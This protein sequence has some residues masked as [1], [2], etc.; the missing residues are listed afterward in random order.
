MPCNICAH[1]F[2]QGDEEKKTWTKKKIVDEWRQA[3]FT[4]FHQ[5]QNLQKK[6]KLYLQIYLSLSS[7]FFVLVFCAFSKYGTC[8]SQNSPINS[9][10]LSCPLLLALV[11]FSSVRPFF[12]R[13]PKLYN[14]KLRHRR[15]E[16]SARG[17]IFF[18]N[19]RS[20]PDRPFGYFGPWTIGTWI[21]KIPLFTLGKYL[22]SPRSLPWL[23]YKVCLFNIFKI[24]LPILMEFPVL[25]W[26]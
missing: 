11:R 13:R 4:L 22:R 10:N 16:M 1:F 8:L 19:R 7:F 21:V 9:R 25:Y 14:P 2:T 6:A 5:W 23:L 17:V 26:Y 15:D 18:L 3:F 12:V 20:L 24:F